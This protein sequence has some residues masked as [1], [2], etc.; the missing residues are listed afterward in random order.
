MSFTRPKEIRLRRGGLPILAI[1]SAP[2]CGQ[3][4]EAAVS[5]KSPDVSV[6]AEVLPKLIGRAVPTLR[7]SRV[8]RK[9]QGDRRVSYAYSD[10]PLPK[11]FFKRIRPCFI[12]SPSSSIVAI[13][14]LWWA[15]RSGS[16]LIL[17][18]YNI[19]ICLVAAALYVAVNKLEPNRH[20]A[21]ALKA[22]IIALAVVA[23]LAHLMQ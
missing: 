4:G 17:S 7:T 9:A 13:E 5:K 18:L 8:Q 15:N 12:P 20:H 23:I 11:S 21:S 2:D 10:S 3:R 1:E 6:G 14:Q 16:L 22:L 19:L